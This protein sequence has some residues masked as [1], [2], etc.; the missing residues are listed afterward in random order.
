[1]V[2]AATTVSADYPFNNNTAFG[3]FAS[4]Y[5]GDSANGGVYSAPSGKCTQTEAMATIMGSGSAAPAA[6]TFGGS[7][8]TP[9]GTYVLTGSSWTTTFTGSDYGAWPTS[10]ASGAFSSDT[11]VISTVKGTVTATLHRSAAPTGASYSSGASWDLASSYGWATVTASSQPSGGAGGYNGTFGSS[12]A[13]ATPNGPSSTGAASP[14]S[15]PIDSAAGA[16]TAMGSML[17]AAGMFV[18][19]AL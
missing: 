9:S 13:A 1:M 18:M 8:F 11:T 7:S 19:I 15:L 6:A 12:S 16:L 2:V 3:T 10:G 4:A 17:A 14:T 5:S